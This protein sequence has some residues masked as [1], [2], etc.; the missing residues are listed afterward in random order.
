MHWEGLCRVWVQHA[1]AWHAFKRVMHALLPVTHAP[2]AS[3]AVAESS[4]GQPERG[5]T[6]RG[7]LN[8]RTSVSAPCNHSMAA[9]FSLLPVKLVESRRTI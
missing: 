8:S 1:R 2:L 3:R 9:V 6:R 4:E 5:V 7:T